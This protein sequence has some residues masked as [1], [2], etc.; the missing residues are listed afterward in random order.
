MLL[1]RQNSTRYTYKLQLPFKNKIKTSKKFRFRCVQLDGLRPLSF[2]RGPH[3]AKRS[4]ANITRPTVYLS[5]CPSVTL[6]YRRRIGCT[7]SKIITRAFAPLSHNI[8]NLVQGEH[9][10]NSGGIVWNSL[11]DELRNSD[12]FDSFKRFLKTIL[13]SRYFDQRILEVIF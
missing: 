7:S 9:P 10:K 4:I 2:Y 5:V 1:T 13:L 8:G 6:M 12:S 11:P 3:S